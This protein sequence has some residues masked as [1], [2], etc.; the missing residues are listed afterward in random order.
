MSC[1]PSASVYTVSDFDTLQAIGYFSGGLIQDGYKTYF[2]EATM[3]WKSNVQS[4]VDGLTTGYYATNKLTVYMSQAEVKTKT[5]AM[6]TSMQSEYCFYIQRY[7]EVLTF[8]LG[9]SG[10]KNNMLQTAV[11][12]NTRLNALI[13]MVNIISTQMMGINAVNASV[14]TQLQRELNARSYDLA[15]QKEFITNK[16]S[17]LTTR[18]EMLRYTGEKNNHIT[19]QISLWAA[20]NVLAIGTIFTIYRNM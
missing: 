11:E 10:T 3:S 6:V 4:Y 8:L 15:A 19:N 13:G 9:A 2:D 18:K 12:L 7:R 1:P 14:I 17:L 5:D 16:D 20:L